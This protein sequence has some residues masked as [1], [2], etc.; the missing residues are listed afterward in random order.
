M[1]LLK[2]FPIQDIIIS[3]DF[4]NTTPGSRKMDRAEQRFRQA[5]KFPGNIVIND[6]NVLIDWYITYL[7]AVK[8]GIR[9]TDLYHGYTEVVEALHYAGSNRMYMWRVPLR[10]AGEITEGDIKPKRFENQKSQTEPDS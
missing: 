3:E 7:L 4:K 1:K 6:E 2:N 10:L 5:G 9:R 8:H